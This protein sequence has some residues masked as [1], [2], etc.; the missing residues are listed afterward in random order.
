MPGEGE[1]ENDE[2]KPDKKR[3]VQSSGA[4][5]SATLPSRTRLRGKTSVK[6]LQA[7]VSR[8]AL[9]EA[10]EEEKKQRR[11]G[12][13]VSVKVKNDHKPAE[14]ELTLKDSDAD[15]PAPAGG[16]STEGSGPARPAV[17]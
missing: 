6:V 9:R 10:A 17:L 13:E 14:K 15:K 16:T 2:L 7:L 12:R 3:R 1:E 8:I 11:N 4:S 5:A